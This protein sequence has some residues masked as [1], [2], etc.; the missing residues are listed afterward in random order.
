MAV[1]ATRGRWAAASAVLLATVAVSPSIRATQGDPP[2]TPI[3]RR[4]LVDRHRVVLRAFDPESPLSVGNGEFAF[5]VDATGLQTF[6]DAFEQT[7]PL[8]TLSNWGWHT[9]PNPGNWGIETFRHQE[10][11]SHGRPVGYA[12]IPRDERTP[13]VEWLR[14][15]PHRL[16][17]GRIGFRLTKVDGT[18]ARPGDLSGVEQ[19]LDVWSG[20]IVSR[21][22]FDG[23]PVE[24]RTVCHPSLDALSVQ[25]TSPLAGSGRLAIEIHFPYGTG[26]TVTADWTRPDAHTTTWSRPRAG[27]ARFARRLDADAYSVEASWAPH[28]ASLAEDARHLFVLS[29]APGSDTLELTASFTP[30]D[31]LA[32]AAEGLPRFAVAAAAAAAATGA[33][34]GRRVAPST[35]P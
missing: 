19:T 28:S 7:T 33:A 21:F 9:A 18:R 23:A 22:T 25:V 8:G 6:P 20:T 13:E 10:F 31:R 34:S 5:A 35:C 16:H 32:S 30:G 26:Q 1:R 29:P 3:D 15:N 4:A 2:P 11:D 17:L 14:A 27:A 24:V 12:D